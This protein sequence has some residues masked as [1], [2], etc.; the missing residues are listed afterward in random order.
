MDVQ[1]PGMDGHDALR[2]LRSREV[3]RHVPVVA[4][5]AFA[6]K[7]DDARALEEGF[8]AYIQKPISVRSLVDQVRGLIDRPGPRGEEP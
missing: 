6:M 2:V 1:L 4:V 3:T 7:G 8:D 5:T